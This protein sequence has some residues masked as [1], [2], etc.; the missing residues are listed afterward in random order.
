MVTRAQQPM[1][2]VRLGATVPG[3]FAGPTQIPWIRELELDIPNVALEDCGEGRYILRQLSEQ[4]LEGLRED[5]ADD[6]DYYSDFKDFLR[7]TES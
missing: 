7:A 4:T 5:L 3:K 1:T 2:T 6:G